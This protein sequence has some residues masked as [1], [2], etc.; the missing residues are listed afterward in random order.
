MD[1]EDGAEDSVFLAILLKL[2]LNLAR[3]S[4]HENTLDPENSFFS[5]YMSY[6][7][8]DLGIFTNWSLNN[9]AVSEFF[10]G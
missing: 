3:S 1:R 5:E 7:L 10:E 8:D 4:D 6:H 9:P 2:L